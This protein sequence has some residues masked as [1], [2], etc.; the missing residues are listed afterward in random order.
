MYPIL[1]VIPCEDRCERGP[2][3]HL[4]DVARPLGVKT[5]HTS[6]L[7]VFEGFRKTRGI[8]DAKF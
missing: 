5:F 4:H 6:N 3:K 8:E 2:P 7:K 1:P